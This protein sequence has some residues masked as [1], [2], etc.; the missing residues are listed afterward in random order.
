MHAR[1]QIREAAVTLIS[2]LTTTGSN[3]YD[4]RFFEL[5]QS[6]VPCWAV[7]TTEEAEE[8]E[9]HAMGGQLARFCKLS[10]VG[11]ARASTGIAL[12]QLLD[13]MCE[14]LETVVLRDSITGAEVIYAGTEWEFD[15]DDSDAAAGRVTVTYGCRYFTNE[16]APG[17]FA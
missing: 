7:Y 10:F 1:Q 16:G 14:E 2:G 11:I 5:E 4:S 12:Q 17:A 3:V 15:E 8:A 6:R 9:I 13:L